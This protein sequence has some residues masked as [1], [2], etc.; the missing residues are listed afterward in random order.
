MNDLIIFIDDILNGNIAD[1][2]GE[3]LYKVTIARIVEWW[4][5]LPMFGIILAFAF[6]LVSFFPGR[7]N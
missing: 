4:A 6:I 2:L 5:V 7:R 1:L 3:E